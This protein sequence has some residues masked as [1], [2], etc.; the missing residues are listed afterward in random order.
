MENENE[1]KSAGI[2]IREYANLFLR[3]VW[4]LILAAGIAGGY[5]YYSSSK[6]TPQYRTST[7]VQIKSGSS[8]Q[9]VNDYASSYYAQEL[10]DTYARTMK[11]QSI[12]DELSRLVGYDVKAGMINVTPIQGTQLMT[13][14]VTDT[15][16]SR[17][18]LIA[19]TLV[20]VFTKQIQNDQAAYYSGSKKIIDDQL[21][22]YNNK[23]QEIT[24]ELAKEMAL[25]G[26]VDENLVRI[27]Q[28]QTTLNYYQQTY[29]SLSQTA[30]QLNISELSSKL[31][32][33]Q[34]DPALIPSSPFEPR[35]LNS[36]LIGALV[37]L[38]AAAG[39]VVLIQFL[40]DSIHDPKEITNRWGVPILGLI[41][42]YNFSEKDL[43]I[44]V[45]SPRSTISESFRTL[46]NNL[47][48]A[49]VDHPINTIV[50][51]SCSGNEGKTTIS[52]N[53]SVVMAQSN[54]TTILLDADLRRPRVHK[55][56]HQ[57][58]H[59]GLTD[60]FIHIEDKTIA[61]I[62]D[63]G[64]EKLSVVT[65]GN[66]PP[67]P[68]ELLGSEKMMEM[69]V[70]LKNQFKSVI[71]DTPPLLA[72]TDALSLAARADGVLLVVKPAITK[73]TELSRGIEQLKQVKANLLGIVINDV[74]V[75]TASSYY[76]K[77]YIS[78]EYGK[79]YPDPKN[80]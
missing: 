6:Q 1:L 43:P 34:K 15:V 25:K 17:A 59:L 11:T 73:W 35:P 5:S 8:F 12:L 10:A 77:Y 19:N 18:A 62:K 13:I 64:I 16:P 32:I 39:V 3:W 21:A 7:L 45:T 75:K 71:I 65:S 63:S 47:Q 24:D 29:F 4:L 68:S 57:T 41:A 76:K 23:I 2:I 30:Q 42:N 53:L 60:Q 54:R 61:A 74:K 40:D 49:S 72:V 20:T 38:I 50:V 67:N 33:I 78:E 80:K 44:T 69:L 70:R 51:T 56:L 28:L 46:R 31:G 79:N 36:G 37:G 48:F 26:T 22:I 58:N 14:T 52:V 9:Q 66:L 55:L 27:S